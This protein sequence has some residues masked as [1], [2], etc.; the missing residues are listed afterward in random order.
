MNT[1]L[2]E[3]INKINNQVGGK[4]YTNI[5]EKIKKVAVVVAIIGIICSIITGIVMINNAL[6]KDYYGDIEVKGVLLFL[7]IATIILG[8]LASWISSFFAYGF[9]ELIVK[10]TEIS[11][12]KKNE[13]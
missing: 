10:T 13:A 12:N 3:K 11:Q 4:M 2:R 7:G 5:G 1:E 6:V 8:S 9:G